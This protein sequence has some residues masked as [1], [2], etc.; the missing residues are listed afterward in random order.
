[1]RPLPEEILADLRWT[2]DHVI[3]PALEDG[4]YAA[5]QAQLMSN[6]LEHLRL[7]ITAEFELLLE[8]CED[9]RRTLGGGPLPPH[10]RQELDLVTDRADAVGIEALRTDND[11]LRKVLQAAVDHLESRADQGDEETGAFL[12]EIRA[13]L[14]RQLDRERQMIGPGYAL[15]T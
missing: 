1:M 6:L 15:G 5:E 13:L 10:L 9:I 7:R 8:D 14:R 11:R 3:R 2:L 12:G 4:G